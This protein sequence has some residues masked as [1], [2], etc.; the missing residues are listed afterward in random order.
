M[1][2][3]EFCQFCGL[4]RRE[5]SIPPAV[6]RGIQ[7][8]VRG[9]CAWCDIVPGEHLRPESDPSIVA[10][11]GFVFLGRRFEF[12]SGDEGIS[13]SFSGADARVTCAQSRCRQV[14]SAPQIRGLREVTAGWRADSPVES[15]ERGW[16]W[17]QFFV[18][19]RSSA[20][21]WRA[22]SGIQGG[23]SLSP[24]TD[25]AAKGG[26][27]AGLWSRRGVQKAGAAVLASIWRPKR[28]GQVFC[29]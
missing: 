5:I 3:D 17:F 7:K 26:E 16:N 10:G 8:V 1:N 29:F 22:A 23:W 9:V 27:E 25:A 19:S 18:S 20:P 11:G 12:G 21:L 4:F 15:H 24:H 6:N 28:Y 2:H 13:V 14:E